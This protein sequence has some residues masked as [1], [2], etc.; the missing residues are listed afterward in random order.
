MVREAIGVAD[1]NGALVARCAQAMGAARAQNA[2]A[3]L[4]ARDYEELQLDIAALEGAD[5]FELEAFTQGCL[6]LAADF[7]L[8]RGHSSRRSRIELSWKRMT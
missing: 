8:Q 2:R 5:D 4:R 3:R 1:T 7:E 6:I